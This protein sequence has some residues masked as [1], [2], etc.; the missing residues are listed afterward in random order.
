MPKIAPIIGGLTIPIYYFITKELI[1][2]KKISLIAS[3]LLAVSTFH[4]YQTSHAAPLTIGHFFMMLSM[5]FFIKY[6]KDQK[7][8]IPLLTTT[9]FLILSH[10]FTTYF[11]IIS[12]T[13]ILFYYTMDKQV[14]TTYLF[15]LIIYIILAATIAFGYWGFI[16]TPVLKYL[17]NNIL[18]SPALIISL[19]YMLVLG[20]VFFIRFL[21][22]H[23]PQILKIRI[24]KQ[25]TKEKT[26]LLTIL[27]IISLLV[28]V[29]FTG[30]PGID[31]KL[32]PLA[33]LF[34]LPMIV[35]IG[36]AT[37]GFSL[38]SKQKGQLF[39]KGWFIGILLSFVYA[40]IS[41]SMYPDRHLEYL[42]VPLCIPAALTLNDLIEDYKE[43]NIKRIFNH[44]SARIQAIHLKKKI[45]LIGS[46]TI[47][48]TNMIVAYP[49]IESLDHIDERL[50]TPCIN[51]MD[52][53]E[54]NVS[55]ASTIVSDHRISML[56]WATGFQIPLVNNTYTIWTANNSTLC[57]PELQ[58]LKIT[59]II[60]DDIMFNKVINVDVGQYYYFTNLS[61]QKFQKAPFELI[62]RNATFNNQ[63]IEQHWIEIY[64]VNYSKMT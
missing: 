23:S 28:I 21:K 35:L 33:V 25:S 58:Q 20:G 62:Y 38:L 27:F 30:I 39:I 50:S 17:T 57:L 47:L 9:V 40:I 48:F 46:I 14:K 63:Q 11:Y 34:S 44:P 56:V 49:T 12:I 4:V 29:I 19:F 7:Y 60:I 36:F 31:A 43:S 55:N 24:L 26:I 8:A 5:Y 59:H 6:I 2:D 42:I 3:S 37:A 52:W 51:C 13:I 61:Y 54:G 45:I 64:K 41:G 10:H 1:G 18:Y 22:T 16:A 53:M 15:H 32:T